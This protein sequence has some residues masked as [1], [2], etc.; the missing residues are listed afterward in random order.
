MSVHDTD[1]ERPEAILELL[2]QR[3]SLTEVLRI[4]YRLCL[5]KR[6]A[7]IHMVGSPDAGDKWERASKHVDNALGQIR[8]LDI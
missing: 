8:C 3:W 5:I 4:I 6:D 7:R 2:L 1:V